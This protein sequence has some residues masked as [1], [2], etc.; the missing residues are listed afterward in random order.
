[1][2]SLP[3]PC[4][5]YSKK[6]NMGLDLKMH[7]FQQTPICDSSILIILGGDT[8]KDVLGTMIPAFLEDAQSHINQLKDIAE[9]QTALD[10]TAFQHATHKLAGV[11]GSFGAY[12]LQQYA[13]HLNMLIH[14]KK[15]AQALDDLPQLFTSYQETK[16]Y[17]LDY[18][19]NI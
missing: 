2:H 17:Y 18:L 19:K 11:S 7:I 4:L 15:Y 1:M 14:E 13:H 16:I 3:T 10:I 5:M 12:Q 6:K 8:P 9:T